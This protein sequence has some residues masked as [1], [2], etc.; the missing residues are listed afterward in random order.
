MP[1]LTLVS[2]APKKRKASCKDL[3]EALIHG[4]AKL[5]PSTPTSNHRADERFIFLREFVPANTG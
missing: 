5:P 3:H 1:H 2:L 4:D